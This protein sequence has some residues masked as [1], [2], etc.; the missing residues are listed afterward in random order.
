MAESMTEGCIDDRN[1]PQASGG[2]PALPH[3]GHKAILVHGIF[4][5]GS[6][7]PPAEGLGGIQGLGGADLQALRQTTSNHRPRS[8]RP[9]TP[10]RDFHPL[11]YRRRQRTGDEPRHAEIPLYRPRL[12][13]RTRVPDRR[14]PTC[15]PDRNRRQPKHRRADDL[16]RPTHRR[17]NCLPQVPTRLDAIRHRFSPPS[18]ALDSALRHLPSTQSSVICPRL[19]H[20]L[21]ICLNAS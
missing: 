15:R 16:G 20:P 17:P 11:E 2:M 8:G 3:T 10:R 13:L 1:R 14:L 12:A 7:L 18:S 5:R 19:S 6:A 9:D 4:V 21:L